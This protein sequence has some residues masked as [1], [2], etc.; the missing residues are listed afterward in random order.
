MHVHCTKDLL[1]TLQVTVSS[2]RQSI[3]ICNWHA[4]SI[5]LNH[6][7]AVVMVNDRTRYVL[8]IYPLVAKDFKNFGNLFLEALAGI[9]KEEGLSPSEVDA[10]IEN[11]SNISFSG[12][13]KRPFTNRIN[14]VC[15]QV[16]MNFSWHRT[17]FEAR[18]VSRAISNSL[19]VEGKG[20]RFPK[21][22]MVR[23]IKDRMEPAGNTFLQRVLNGND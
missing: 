13:V 15:D 5:I 8:V 22:E 18:Q 20:F 23:E 19:V 2:P 3:D 1:Q 9:L 10:F 4:N 11:N 12:I 6:R 14:Q 16:K 21:K 7:K 17:D